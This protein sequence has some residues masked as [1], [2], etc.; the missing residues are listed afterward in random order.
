[1]VR[2]VLV[3]AIALALCAGACKAGDRS[4][5]VGAVYPTGGAQG[6][7]GADEYRGA[8]LA[9]ELANSKGG[10]NGR[11]VRL[12]L[13]PA[14]SADGVPDAMKK[15]AGRTS[16]VLGSYGSTISSVAAR[17][18]TQEDLVFWETGAVGELPRDV[19]RSGRVFRV[20]P[21]G[22]SLGANAVKFVRD[23]VLPKR[24][25]TRPVRYAVAY[26]NDVYGRSVGLGAIA[27]IE[28][29]GGHPAV[30]PY[31][32]R[33]T[34]FAAIAKKIGRARTDVLVVG[35]YLEDGVALRAELSKR[36]VPL[37]ASIGTSSS[38]CMPEFG[39]L[40][41]PHAVGLFASDK[42]DALGLRADRLQ[43]QAQSALV[44]ARAA[45]RKRFH[46]PMSAPALSGF[47]GAW[48]LVHYVL[49][50]AQD[51]SAEAIAT[52]AREVNVPM[53]ALPNGSGLAFAKRSPENQ[54]AE[55]VIWEWVKPN[56]RAIVWPKRFATQAVAVLPTR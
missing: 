23:V 16:V 13:V 6:M 10:V 14:D 28:G 33:G 37:L 5:V 47:A 34:D 35:A 42:P 38:Y 53:G 22:T 12:D 49:P 56:T 11:S 46:Q 26:V 2:R 39:K 1:M 32:V 54:R 25:V 45:Y 41:G 24:G 18:A 3:I 8:Q 55:S 15:L 30:F 20:P 44:W 21:M 4:L 43:P 51:G 48:A 17:I 27:E 7:G 52:S 40:L 19:E 29:N 36:H 9:F 50:H 31:A